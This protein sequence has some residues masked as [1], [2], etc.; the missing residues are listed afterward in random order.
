[1]RSGICSLPNDLASILAPPHV[2]RRSMYTQRSMTEQD[3]LELMIR[4]A[5][6]AGRAAFQV[7]QG[8]FEVQLKADDS[9]VTAADHAAERIILESL[10]RHAP[11]LPII[12]EEQVALG[13]VPQH[14]MNFLLVD[15]L[16]GTREFIKRNGEFTVNIALVRDGSP[17]LGVV[18]APAISALF[19]GNVLTGKAWRSGQA[20]DAAE[21]AREPIK[22]RP[23]PA[24]G[25][26]VV[27]SR[28]HR[29]PETDAYLAGYRVAQMVSVGSSLKFC[30][31]AAGEADLYPRLGT[32]MEWDTAAGQAV[33]VAAGGRVLTDERSVLAYAKPEYRNPWFV[34][35]GSADVLPLLDS[36]S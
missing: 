32:T 36:E 31:V 35:T 27:A 8:H 7:Y 2:C 21:A 22:V 28:S 20:P 6:S 9:P 13:R 17:V 25:I 16:D 19:A 10:G 34:A 26:T 24:E 15:P 18:Y 3:L 23:V 33:L 30:K 4:A 14:G 12:A 11:E 29:S 5:I 1:M